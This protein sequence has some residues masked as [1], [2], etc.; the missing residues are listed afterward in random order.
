MDTPEAL[1]W[2]QSHALRTKA[3]KLIRFVPDSAAGITKVLQLQSH[4]HLHKL[5]L[6]LSPSEGCP[7]TAKKRKMTASREYWYLSRELMKEETWYRRRA[8]SAKSKGTRC[9]ITVHKEMESMC[10]KSTK[11]P[12][13]FRFVFPSCFLLLFDQ[14]C[15]WDEDGCRKGDREKSISSGRSVGISRYL[16]AMPV[17][18]QSALAPIQ[19]NGTLG[20]K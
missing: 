13:F 7:K 2:K 15:V 1:H 8:N 19:N 17:R 3:D 14:N 4:I 6:L 18:G 20:G 5:S 12:A 16:R 10:R 9:I 11:A